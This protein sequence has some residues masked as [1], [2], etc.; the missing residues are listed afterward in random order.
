MKR[1]T[2]ISLLGG[3]TVWPVVARGQESGTP[4]IG[5]LS[6]G[7]P[8]ASARYL[9]A[10]R[11]GLSEAGFVEGRNVTIEQ[12][13]AGAELGRLPELAADLVRRRVT[14]IASLSTTAALAAKS[15]TT[16]IPIVF[17]SGGDP[18]KLGLVTRPDGNVTGITNMSPE[19]ES[20]RVEFLHELVPEATRY[21]VLANPDFPISQTIITA[22]RS[23]VSGTGRQIEVFTAVND[24]EIDIAFARLVE[25]RADALLVAPDT[26]FASRRVR[27]V[28][29]AMGHMLPA[30]YFDRQFAEVGGLMSYGPSY[31][32]QVRQVGIYT[33]RILKGAKPADLPV[34]QLTKFELV[35]N[36]QT[37][38]ALGI[39]VPP[40]LLAIADEVIE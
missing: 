24:L 16:T 31:A 28:T 27:L 1:R 22:L 40:G 7:T 17:M 21:A 5:L 29:M 39:E 36:L 23:A 19:L 25:K 20:K 10:F 26:L 13:W 35:I 9:E 12:R 6:S 33:G 11:M 2:F 34:L 30:L 15:A 4:V 37:A 8:E 18:V 32:K 14:V 3:A 38:R